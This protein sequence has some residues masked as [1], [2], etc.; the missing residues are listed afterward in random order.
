MTG[1]FGAISFVA[2]DTP[3]AQAALDKLAE[4]Y[5]NA[6]PA[7]ADVVVALGGDGLMLQTLHRFLG[8]GKPIYGMA[9]AFWA[10]VSPIAAASTRSAS[11]RTGECART[12]AATSLCSAIRLSA[13]LRGVCIEGAISSAIA[14]RTR[15]E[16]SS[17]KAISAVSA[18]CLSSSD[19][20]EAEIVLR[21][22]I[23]HRIRPRNS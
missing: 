19:M 18:S 11:V 5:G 13:R 23:D 14:R 7:A 8:T 20:H 1:R 16:G 3:E 21:G 12:S 22:R 6:D 17:I 2:S 15:G 4:R 10:S 9:M